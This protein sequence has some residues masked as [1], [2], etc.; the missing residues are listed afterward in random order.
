MSNLGS[1]CHDNLFRAPNKGRTFVSKEWGWEDWIVN[2]EEYCGKILFLK[3][4]MNTSWHFHKIKDEVLYVNQGRVDIAY[5]VKDEYREHRK[6]EL[7][8]GDSFHVARELR[9]RIIALEDTYL[10]E[11]STQHFDDDSH[12]LPVDVV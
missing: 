9:H 5:G 6:Q 1:D 2:K 3:K 10:F 7:T 11:F 8:P 12:R 4:G